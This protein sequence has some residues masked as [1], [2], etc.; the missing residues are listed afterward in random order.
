MTKFPTLKKA[1]CGC[2]YSATVDCDP[3]SADTRELRLTASIT[4]HEPC[5]SHA[6]I[7]TTSDHVLVVGR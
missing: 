7:A 2:S 3:D 5:P 6:D 4:I 1:P